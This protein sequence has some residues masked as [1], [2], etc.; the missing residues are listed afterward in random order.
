MKVRVDTW[1]ELQS[2]G[3][4]LCYDDSQS[5][6]AVGCGDGTK[7]IHSVAAGKIASSIPGVEHKTPITC[8]KYPP[9]E[10]RW[11]PQVH[12]KNKVLLCSDS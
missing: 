12:S 2:E 7:L 5:C 3:N 10:C 4:T 1:Q 9:L 11:R 6:M 8:L